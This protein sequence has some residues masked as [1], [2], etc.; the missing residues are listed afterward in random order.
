[1]VLRRVEGLDRGGR[2]KIGGGGDRGGAGER[3]CCWGGV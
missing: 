1:M 2:D 3:I